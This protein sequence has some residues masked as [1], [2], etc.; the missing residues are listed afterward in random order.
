MQSC[1][2][3]QES[4]PTSDFYGRNPI[5]KICQNAKNREAYRQNHS[6]QLTN[7]SQ[8]LTTNQHQPQ[9]TTH[10][11]NRILSL[12]Q[13]LFTNAKDTTGLKQRIYEM[14]TIVDQMDRGNN[15]IIFKLKLSIKLNE[16]LIKT[17]RKDFNVKESL[18]ILR[19]TIPKHNQPLS[20]VASNRMLMFQ[21]TFGDDVMDLSRIIWEELDTLVKI[22]EALEVAYRHMIDQYNQKIDNKFLNA[23]IMN[24]D[25]FSITFNP[26]ELEII[27]HN[28]LK[29]NSE[30]FLEILQ[31]H[32]DEN[33]ICMQGYIERGYYDKFWQILVNHS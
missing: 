6:K 25:A 5:C 10:L 7:T 21:E 2:N 32:V 19:E 8:N 30:K 27:I 3:C 29:Y 15:I 18:K 12:Q 9:M 4:K 24:Y 26:D 11:M 1:T 28:P 22:M 14:L 17:K 13:H 20:Q 23:S 33:P 31:Q 16:F